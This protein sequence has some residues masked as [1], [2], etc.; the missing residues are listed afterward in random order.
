MTWIGS[1]FLAHQ[2]KVHLRDYGQAMHQHHRGGREFTARR[3]NHA[4]SNQ[5]IGADYHLAIPPDTR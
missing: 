4:L 5:G 3:P 2:S 1:T